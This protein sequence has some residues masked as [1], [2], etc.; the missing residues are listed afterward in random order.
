[1]YLSVDYKFYLFK[2]SD[3]IFKRN[4]IYRDIQKTAMK[5]FYSSIFNGM[6]EIYIVSNIP[7]QNI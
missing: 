1:M 3:S 2:V 4:E 6:F 5:I 7:L